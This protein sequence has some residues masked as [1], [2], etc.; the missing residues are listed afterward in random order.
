MAIKVLVEVKTKV[1]KIKNQTSALT[2]KKQ[3]STLEESGCSYWAT[4]SCCN[5]I[6]GYDREDVR[7][8]SGPEERSDGGT[9]ESGGED[10][11]LP[12]IYYRR[13]FFCIYCPSCL[14]SIKVSRPPGLIRK[15]KDR[16]VC[17]VCNGGKYLIEV[18]DCGKCFYCRGDGVERQQLYPNT[19]HAHV[20]ETA[21]RRCDGTG[22]ERERIQCKCE[23]CDGYG[24]LLTPM[25]K[26]FFDYEQFGS[27]LRGPPRDYFG[28]RN[29]DESEEEF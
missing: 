14:D 21:C 19:R 5:S 20:I 24:Q 17:D 6:I 10:I 2:V 3:I 27:T 1:R 26:D 11:L 12:T 18:R 15:R 28:Y 22:K 25:E 23:K 16:K 9:Y 4:C 8:D 13:K 7:C 29:I